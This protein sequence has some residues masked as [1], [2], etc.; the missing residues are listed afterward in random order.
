MIRKISAE[1]RKSDS[2]REFPAGY[3]YPREP[4]T[5]FVMYDF[6]SFAAKQNRVRGNNQ[7]SEMILNELFYSNPKSLHFYF[8]P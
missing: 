6:N 7:P 8:K 3:S 5:I 2:A 4:N 1:I